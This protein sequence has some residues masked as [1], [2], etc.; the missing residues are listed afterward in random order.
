M[1]PLPNTVCCS[2]RNNLSDNRHPFSQKP[3]KR[4][5]LAFN[6]NNH[7]TTY[8]FRKVKVYLTISDSF[9]KFGYQGCSAFV[10]NNQ[11]NSFCSLLCCTF[12]ILA[13]KRKN[14]TEKHKQCKEEN[15]HKDAYIKD[16][17]L[18]LSREDCLIM[19]RKVI[20]DRK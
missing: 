11:Y 1:L 16:K 10:I 12:Y 17:L 5:L 8:K 3:V 4:H 13:Q 9:K 7:R 19:S 14:V 15:V 18:G 2:R 6:C 20:I